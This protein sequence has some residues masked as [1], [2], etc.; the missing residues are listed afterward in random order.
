MRLYRNIFQLLEIYHIY[1]YDKTPTLYFEP[2]EDSDI[3]RGCWA[4]W[5]NKPA[6]YSD[7]ILIIESENSPIMKSTMNFSIYNSDLMHNSRYEI[8]EFIT[9]SIPIDSIKKSSLFSGEIPF[10]VLEILE[11]C[12]WDEKEVTNF[13]NWYK[14]L[15]VF[16]WLEDYIDIKLI[17]KQ[18]E[19]TQII[20]NKSTGPLTGD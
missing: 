7:P 18:K 20:K 6:K 16:D 13:E 2:N 5:F 1:K 10:D 19:L 8:D 11:I 12:H 3:P 9:G 14:S 17:S 4:F 15:T